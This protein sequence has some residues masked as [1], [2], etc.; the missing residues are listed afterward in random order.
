MSD[1]ETL[2]VYAKKAQEYADLT[3]SAAENDPSLVAFIAAMPKG[4]RVLDLGCGPGASA[5]AMAK[6]GLR[7]DAYDPVPQMVA[8]AAQHDAVTARQAGFH[9]L[10]GVD[11]YDGIWANFSLLHAPRA[12][13]PSHLSRIA[14][15]LKPAGVFHIAVKTGTGSHRDRIGRLYTYYTE[16]ELTRLLSDAGLTVTSK[17]EGSGKGLSGEDAEWL[18]LSAHG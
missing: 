3:D 12:E 7:T 17:R 14:K 10:C 8:L 18:A 9:D 4:A 5:A 15:A 1:T 2:A 13:L 6:A 11:I 16:T